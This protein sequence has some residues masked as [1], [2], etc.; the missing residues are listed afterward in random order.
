MSTIDKREFLGNGGVSMVAIALKLKNGSRVSVAGIEL[1][2][3]RRRQE[4][5]KASNYRTTKPTVVR[6]RHLHCGVISSYHHLCHFVLL[7][8]QCGICTISI[9]IV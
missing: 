7:H 4:A 9:I 3:R 1:T 8:M 2:T 6:N 5:R